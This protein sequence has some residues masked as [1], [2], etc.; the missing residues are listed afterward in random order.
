MFEH[1][2]ERRRRWFLIAFSATAWLLFSN[3]LAYMGSTFTDGG[4][5]PD[6]AHAVSLVGVAAAWVLLV[7][8]FRLRCRHYVFAVLFGLGLGSLLTEIGFD[9][10]VAAGIWALGCDDGNGTACHNLADYYDGG[11][12]PI[13]GSLDS[14]PLHRRACELGGPDT[15]ES[16]AVAR[17]LGLNTKKGTPSTS[18]DCDHGARSACLAV[19]RRLEASGELQAA[20]ARYADAC[21]LTRPGDSIEGCSTLLDSGYHHRRLVACETLDTVCATS[22]ARSCIV[23]TRRCARA[24]SPHAGVS[25]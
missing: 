24:R 16:C 21:Q 1:W 10:H 13:G 4:I 9:R 22:G 15:A 12:S 23:A 25:P 3:A 18:R 19:A 8:A 2:S 20:Y 14:G 17:S 11:A 5:G 7:S 6:A